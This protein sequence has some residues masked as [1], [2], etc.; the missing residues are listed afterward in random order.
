MTKW[1]HKKQKKKAKKQK[2][3]GKAKGKAQVSV[4]T[5]PIERLSRSAHTAE[6]KIGE[7]VSLQD[8]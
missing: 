4:A 7:K 6:N 3:K 8:R 1:G 5:C 2:A